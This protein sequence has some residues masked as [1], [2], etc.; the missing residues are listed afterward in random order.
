MAVPRSSRSVC[1]AEPLAAGEGYRVTCVT[2]AIEN[3]AELSSRLTLEIPNPFHFDETF[4]LS[5]EAWEA[6]IAF[7]NRWTRVP[8]LA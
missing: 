5:S 1:E 2:E 7:N 4:E 8:R 3:G 6:P